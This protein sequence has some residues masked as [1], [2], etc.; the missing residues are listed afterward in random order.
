MK[1]A[2]VTTYDVSNSLTWPRSQLGLCGA[3]ANIAKALK[4][5]SIS[6]EYLGPLNKKTS[7]ITRAKWGLYRNFFNKDYYRWA[8][9]L[10]LKNYAYQISK[11]LS[12]FNSDI[13]LCPEN[14]VPIAYLECKQPLV[15]WTD[16]TLAGL[17]DFYPYLSNLCQE[18]KENIYLMEQAALNKCELVILASEWAAQTAI[19]IYGIASSKVKVVPRG[20]NIECNRNIDNIRTLVDSRMPNPCKLL[21]LGVDWYRK[22]GDVALE[23]TKQLNRMGLE[24]ELTVVGCQPIT[25]EPLP[26]FVKSLG[27]L[28]KSTQAGKNRIDELL[29]DTHFLILPSRAECYGIVFCEANSFGVPCLATNIG[30]IPT[31]VK[32]NVNGRTFSLDAPISNYCNYIENIMRNYSKYKELAISS[33]NDYQFRANWDV[34]SKRA[35]QLF[36][37]LTS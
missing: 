18:T 5:Q 1:I 29:S 9:P 7:I 6:L 2:Y 22:G 26:S 34:A 16:S 35:K 31:S 10:V 8:E 12:K 19:D 13:V 3:G 23:V 14:A 20:P 33:F 36:I 32:D 4:S 15:L 30:G 25:G 11:K 27:F 21:F 37:Q 28:N 17:I 24:A